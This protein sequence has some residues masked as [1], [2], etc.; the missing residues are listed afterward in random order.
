MP[1]IVLWDRGGKLAGCPPLA[2]LLPCSHPA[3]SLRSCAQALGAPRPQQS[4][5]GTWGS[6]TCR[7]GNRV[8]SPEMSPRPCCPHTRLD[9]RA[10]PGPRA[11]GPWETGG[12][13]SQA[14]PGEGRVRGVTGTH[15]P[16]STLREQG[17]SKLFLTLGQAAWVFQVL[18][19]AAAVPSTTPL[20]AR[21]SSA[22][23]W[24]KFPHRPAGQGPGM[25]HQWGSQPGHPACLVVP[26]ETSTRC[27]GQRAPSQDRGAEP[28]AHKP[29]WGSGPVQSLPL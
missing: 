6:P 1:S 26:L 16:F 24:L 13:G 25:R 17:S 21:K 10:P 29:W 9:V 3:G 11:P 8:L 12:L 15:I 27:T 19:K 23:F 18:A 20:R 4:C 2:Q 22:W 7:Q 14:R 5:V 28:S